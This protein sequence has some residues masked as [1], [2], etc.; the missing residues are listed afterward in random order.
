MTIEERLAK[1]E[2]EIGKLKYPLDY[3]LQGAIEQALF[4]NLNTLKLKAGLHIFTQA[5]TDKPREGELYLTNI[6]GTRKICAYIG[7][8]EYTATLT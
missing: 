5:R 3:Q 7:G 1:L 6:A 2:K 8:T 4:K